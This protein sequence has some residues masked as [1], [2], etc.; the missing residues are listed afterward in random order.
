MTLKEKLLKA[1]K[2]EDIRHEME[3]YT[4]AIAL[5]SKYKEYYQQKVQQLADK[6]KAL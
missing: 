3:S 4:N 5:G 2:V 6:L 1:R